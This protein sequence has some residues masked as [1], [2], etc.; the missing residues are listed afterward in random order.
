MSGCGSWPDF[1]RARELPPSLV[2]KG[3]TDRGIYWD[4]GMEGF[5]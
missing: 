1:A 4:T 5:T 3:G 2:K